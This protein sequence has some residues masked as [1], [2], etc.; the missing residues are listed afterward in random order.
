MIFL[1]AT[2]ATTTSGVGAISKISALLGSAL[3]IF[4]AMWLVIRQFCVMC[5]VFSMGHPF[6]PFTYWYA[7]IYLS[8]S[9]DFL[10]CAHLFTQ[11][12]PTILDT[13]NAHAMITFTR[14]SERPLNH[15]CLHI[16]R[17]IPLWNV[18]SFSHISTEIVNRGS[19]PYLDEKNIYCYVCAVTLEFLLYFECDWLYKCG[20]SEWKNTLPD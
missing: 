17:N 20:E 6:C 18:T 14:M 7:P 2:T 13:L 4:L 9:F 15:S 3:L 8:I 11:L 12:A 19:H 1:D 5:H 16:I 10:C